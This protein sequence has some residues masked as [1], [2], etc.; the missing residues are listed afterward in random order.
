MSNKDLVLNKYPLA[1]YLKDEPCHQKDIPYFM[2][3]TS[4]D[5]GGIDVLGYSC[6]SEDDAWSDAWINIGDL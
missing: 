5:D 3:M 6:E 2:I 4:S 1:K